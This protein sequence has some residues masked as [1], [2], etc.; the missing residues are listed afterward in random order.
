MAD[1][2]A[3][4]GWLSPELA[5][6]IRRVKGVKLLCHFG[7]YLR[8]D[9][10]Y[11]RMTPVD[12]HASPY[13]YKG[14]EHSHRDPF[15]TQDFLFKRWGGAAPAS[16]HQRGSSDHKYGLKQRA[17]CRNSIESMVTGALNQSL[18]GCGIRK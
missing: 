16:A 13:K 8:M 14:P 3:E 2:S 18:R 10:R 1:E 7:S 15:I 11:L 6:G 9:E 12:R 5:I 17:H 4:S